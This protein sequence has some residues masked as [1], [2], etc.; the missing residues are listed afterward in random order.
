MVKIAG[1]LDYLFVFMVLL[2]WLLR[3]LWWCGC[4]CDCGCCF[5]SCLLRL[6]NHSSS[7]A[8]AVAVAAA[9]PGSL[10]QLLQSN[11]PRTSLLALVRACCFARAAVSKTVLGFDEWKSR[12]G[13]VG[14]DPGS[15]HSHAH[16]GGDVSSPM[17]ASLPTRRALSQQQ[18]RRPVSPIH[19]ASGED[20]DGDGDGEGT[21]WGDMF[22]GTTA[23]VGV[24][25]AS[26]L[27]PAGPTHNPFAPSA[28]Q[29]AEGSLPRSASSTGVSRLPKLAGSGHK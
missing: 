24:P 27:T 9:G 19:P 5:C 20:G 10:P 13:V 12:H 29:R 16:F 11:K 7:V 14:G 21:S 26:A 22:G 3:L 1:P 6:L 4:G 15:S 18:L 8:A 25:R 28:M 17:Q 2:L 23:S